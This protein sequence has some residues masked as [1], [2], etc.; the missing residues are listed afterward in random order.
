MLDGVDPLDE[1]IA[2]LD[3]D[4]FL[5]NDRPRVDT[6]VDVMNG[7]TRAVDAGVKGVVDWMRAGKL[8]QE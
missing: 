7:D 8:R 3:R 1:R 2:W 6:R 4:R 5:A